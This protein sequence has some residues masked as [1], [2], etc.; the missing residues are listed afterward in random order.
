MDGYTG[1]TVGSHPSPGDVSICLYCRSVGIFQVSPIGVTVR[2]A[3]FEEL[4]RLE[5]DRRFRMARAALADY[6]RRWG[7]PRP[8]G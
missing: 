1:T 5:Q 6:H 3:T 2:P 7:M 8:P 4:V